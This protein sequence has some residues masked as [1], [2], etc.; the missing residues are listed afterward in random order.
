MTSLSDYFTMASSDERREKRPHRVLVVDCEP[1]LTRSLGKLL[2]S[3]GYV[4]AE[5]NDPSKA[6]STAR[7]FRPDIILLDLHLPWRDGNKVVAALAADQLLRR[8]PIIFM[9]ADSPEQDKPALTLPILV[10]PFT[11]DALL[12][13]LVEA[14]TK[15]SR[16]EDT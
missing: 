10:K 11:I 3:H 13:R 5:E 12:A 8:L 14:I 9:T 16:K 7:R 6:L 4:A 1:L 2:R 15:T